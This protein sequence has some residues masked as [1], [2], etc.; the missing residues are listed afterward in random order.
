MFLATLGSGHALAAGAV[1]AIEFYN[2]TLDH[3]FV[4]ASSDEIGKLDAG[5]FIGWTRT[6]LTFQV[7]DPTTATP[8]ASAVCRF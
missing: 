3:Y 6:G 7:L 5:V 4:T 1:D 8:F 2:A